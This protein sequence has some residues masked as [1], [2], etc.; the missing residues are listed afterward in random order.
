MSTRDL[1]GFTAI[2]EGKMPLLNWSPGALAAV[3]SKSQREEMT[4]LFHAYFGVAGSEAIKSLTGSN[5]HLDL[6]TDTKNRYYLRAKF[7]K[8]TGWVVHAELK[9]EHRTV[10]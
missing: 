9:H 2:M 6:P 5:L 3:R 1:A 8:E 4:R 7:T 10:V